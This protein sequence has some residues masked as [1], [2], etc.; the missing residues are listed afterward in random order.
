MK[1]ETLEIIY[2]V[3]VRMLAEGGGFLVLRITK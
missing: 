3:C 2:V 1:T